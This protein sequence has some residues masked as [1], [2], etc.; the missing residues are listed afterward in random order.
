[1]LGL[2]PSLKGLSYEERFRIMS[3]PS[4]EH[5]QRRSDKLQLYK[6]L[7]VLIE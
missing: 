7:D 3:L 2:I 1:M 5:C 6:I 4:L